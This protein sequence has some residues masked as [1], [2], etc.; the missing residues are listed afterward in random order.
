MN[1][2]G[3]ERFILRHGAHGIPVLGFQIVKKCIGQQGQLV[4]EM[5]IDGAKAD[6]GM[7]GHPPDG[8]TVIVLAFKKLFRAFEDQRPRLSLLH[9]APVSFWLFHSIPFTITHIIQ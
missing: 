7:G 6:L 9:L 4:G 8:H 1:K 3:L 5:L 2:L